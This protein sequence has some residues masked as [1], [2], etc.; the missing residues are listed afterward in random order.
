MAVI[1]RSGASALIPEEYSREIFKAVPEASTVMRLARRLPN[2]SRAQ[3]RIPVLAG[4]IQGGW[5]SGE[6]SVANPNHGLKRTS[7]ANWTNVF[8][9]IEE[10]AVI[11]PIPQAVLDDADYDIWGEVQPQ[12]AEEFGRIFDETVMIGSVKPSSF[13]LSLLDGATA[14]GHVV[15]RG[16]GV[17]LYDELLSEGGVVAAVEEDGFL[18]NGI[19]SALN[20]RASLRGLRDTAGQPI[21]LRSMQETTRY[22]LD[23]VS[24]EFPR[25]GAIDPSEALAFAA[26]WDQIVW[27]MRQ[28]MTYSI[29]REATIYDT[30]GTTILHR[31]AQQ[32]MVALRAVMRV[33]WALPNPINRVNDNASTRYPAAVLVPANGEGDGDG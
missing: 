15:A 33:G 17:D 27:A 9:N 20:L 23:G 7:A 8:L 4:L 11:V 3:F 32:D 25:N 5:V 6:A 24:V 2:V 16:S 19:V 14:A 28:D 13:P 30:D 31:L 12:I 10:I 18:V 1:D 26:D 29:L 22:E 21:F